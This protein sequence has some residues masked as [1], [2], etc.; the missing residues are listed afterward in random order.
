MDM[1]KPRLIPTIVISTG[2][3]HVN[4]LIAS[5]ITSSPIQPDKPNMTPP[6]TTAAVVPPIL[7][8][9]T[10]SKIVSIVCIRNENAG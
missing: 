8:K 10:Y 7:W 1:N 6:A 3:N 4:F 9:L 5:L 2:K